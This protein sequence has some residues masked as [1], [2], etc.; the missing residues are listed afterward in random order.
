[1][2]V[3]EGSIPADSM[4]DSRSRRASGKASGLGNENSVPAA[5]DCTAFNAAWRAGSMR[6]ASTK[7]SSMMKLAEALF[8]SAAVARGDEGEVVI[9]R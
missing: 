9:V 3:S 2:N 6:P 5:Q 1:M 7:W 4:G 8:A